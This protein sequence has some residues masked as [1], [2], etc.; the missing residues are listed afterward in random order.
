MAKEHSA[1]ALD[2]SGPQALLV[3]ISSE[4]GLRS[5]FGKDDLPPTGANT[6]E[7]YGFSIP[8]QWVTWAITD[9]SSMATKYGAPF[10]LRKRH[11]R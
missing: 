7:V 8:A 9:L 10:L 4:N 5:A 2:I 1:I 11:T 6:T 3:L